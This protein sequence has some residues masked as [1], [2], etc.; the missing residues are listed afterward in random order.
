MGAPAS[1]LGVEGLEGALRA[2]LLVACMLTGTACLTPV[3]SP[4]SLGPASARRM[5]WPPAPAAARIEWLAEIR[6]P[7]DLGIRP[8]RLRRIWNWMSGAPTARLLR[9]HGVS[10]DGRG[11]LWVTDPGAKRVHVFDTER[12]RY[13]A[14]PDEKAAAFVSPIAVAHDGD[15]VAYITDSAQGLIRRVGADLQELEAWDGGG[16]LERP[17]GLAFDP[18]ARLLWVVD[19]GNHRLVALDEA[20]TIRRTVGARG[21]QPGFFNFPT[22]LAIDS[23]GRLFVTDTLNFRVQILSPEG[24]PLAVIGEL[25][26]GP[27]ALSKPKGV[28]LD[29][30]GHVYV[31]DGAFDNV[32]I[33]DQ[34]GRLLLHF[35]TQ[36]VTRGEFWLPAGLCVAG[37]DRIY[38]ADGFN[39]RVQAFRYLRE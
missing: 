19:T 5:I 3:E 6:E 38:V 11:R 26:D 17:T 7:E 21:N 27:G 1:P 8:G 15:G 4:A 29:S 39:R 32:Q 16:A 13:R 28:A 18:A 9:P 34:E 2:A 10:V 36:G 24:K 30:D 37:G 33:F 31:V 12:G 25:G 35:G 22:H 23:S 14:L 20:G